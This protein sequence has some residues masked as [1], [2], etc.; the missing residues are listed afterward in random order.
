VAYLKVK[1]KSEEFLVGRPAGEAGASTSSDG[2]SLTVEGPR[3]AASANQ[4]GV[5][6]ARPDCAEIHISREVRKGN[7]DLGLLKIAVDSQVWDNRDK[8]SP[9]DEDVWPSAEIDLH[10]GV[11]SE[12]IKVQTIY[13]KRLLVF[14][15]SFRWAGEGQDMLGGSSFSEE[16]SMKA[17][18]VAVQST[19]GNVSHTVELDV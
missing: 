8:P 19:N 18:R 13:V 2:E 10:H 16:L 6:A 4:F 11:G 1:S 9:A 12:R 14:S 5:F 15:W 17:L 7:G 3:L